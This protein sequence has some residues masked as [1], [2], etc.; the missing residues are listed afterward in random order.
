MASPE[1]AD[2]PL[3]KIEAED[4]RDGTLFDL[5]GTPRLCAS[6]APFASVMELIIQTGKRFTGLLLHRLYCSHRGIGNKS[7]GGILSR[8]SDNRSGKGDVKVQALSFSRRMNSRA[9]KARS[10]PS[11]TS[12]PR[13]F[14]E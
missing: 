9:T 10:P 7:D 12:T 3:K 8:Y 1:N 5:R 13:T 14:L 11:G 2:N 6:A 4:R